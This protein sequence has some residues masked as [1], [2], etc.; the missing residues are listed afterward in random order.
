VLL[1]KKK[2]IGLVKE[3]K[4]KQEESLALLNKMEGLR[5]R[6]IRFMNILDIDDQGI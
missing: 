3:V 4:R 6:E 1:L 2:K 5:G